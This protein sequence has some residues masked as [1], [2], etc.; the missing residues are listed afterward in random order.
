MKVLEEI[1]KVERAA[2]ERTD[3]ALRVAATIAARRDS[4]VYAGMKAFKHSK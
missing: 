4:A 3:G 1:I 2:W